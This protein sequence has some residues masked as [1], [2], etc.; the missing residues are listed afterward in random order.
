L[1]NLSMNAK[2]GESAELL[3]E[4]LVESHLLRDTGAIPN[5]PTLPVLIY[6]QAI[7]VGEGDVASEIERLLENNHWG[8]SWRNGIY[9]YH[10]YHST[11]HEVLIGF[12]GEATIQL[13]GEPGM[14]VN[15]EAGDVIILPAGT[16]HKRLDQKRDFKIIGAYPKGQRWDMCY[17]NMG[18]RPKAD[19]NIK[20][21]PL[22]RTD[23]I[24]GA[25]GPLIA[26]WRLE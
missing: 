5:N 10:H 3:N 15:F 9:P 2:K 16:G 19:E 13:G 18:E 26:N 21:V 11:A 6:K 14:T 4:P 17:G 22:P 24:Y 23:P 7:K 8:G 1:F 25:E 20:R 12:S